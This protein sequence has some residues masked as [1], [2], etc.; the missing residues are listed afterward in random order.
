M[1]TYYRLVD[2]VKKNGVEEKLA[3]KIVFEILSDLAEIKKSEN[4]NPIQGGLSINVAD[5]VETRTY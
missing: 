2:I 5:Q 3:Q 4:E 1:G